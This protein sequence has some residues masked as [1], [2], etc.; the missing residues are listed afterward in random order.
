MGAS[1]WEYFTPYDSDISGALQ[2]LRTRVFDAGDYYREAVD[3]GAAE[4][5]LDDMRALGPDD[6][7]GED[8]EEFLAWMLENDIEAYRRA[9]QPVTDIASLL[10]VQA[11]SGTH[12]I[13]DITEGVSPT[14]RDG[15]VSPMTG[16]ELVMSF[17]TLEPSHEQVRAWLDDPRRAVSRDRG[18][19]LYVVIFDGGVPSEICF[20]GHSGD[21]GR[22]PDAVSRLSRSGNMCRP[23]SPR[24]VSVGRSLKE[25]TDLPG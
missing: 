5:T 18:Q 8:L 19:G 11:E 23:A 10:R 13:L 22:R 9:R 17:G 21:K 14:P 2:A 25:T 3:P 12:S 20:E 4:P 16:E 6:L 1:A 24:E 15:A 7:S